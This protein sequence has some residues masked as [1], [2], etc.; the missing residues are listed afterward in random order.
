[1]ES[2][3]SLPTAELHPWEWP[4]QPWLCLHIDFAGPVQSKYFLVLV[5]AHSK[6]VEIFPTNGP[7]TAKTIECLRHCFCSL[8][9]PV[10][11]VSDNGTC[12]TSQE[13]KNF[14]NANGI[15]HVTSAVYKPVTNSLAERMVQTFKNALAQSKESHTTLLD[16]FLFK[17]WIT[18]HTTTGFLPSELLFKRK[19]R[20][21]LNLLH[22]SDEVDSRVSSSQEFQKKY[23]TASRLI[24]FQA[25]TPV[26]VR[27]Y[28]RGSKWSPATVL[29]KHGLI[30]HRCQLDNGQVVKQ[31]Q[32]QVIA[33]NPDNPTVFES[34]VAEFTPLSPKPVSPPKSLRVEPHVCS[35]TPAISASIPSADVQPSTPAKLRR[36]SRQVRRPDCLN[37]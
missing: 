25:Q 35:P 3:N 22:P 32:A 5:D 31:H 24:D 27:N 10:T 2:C 8:G 33:G 15:R 18:P 37:L 12:F 14:L 13:F 16:K 11:I 29:D 20:C 1:M 26:L 9:L 23:H 17:Y 6:W 28:A 7:S 36:S 21:R 30:S 34:P 4:S 19:L